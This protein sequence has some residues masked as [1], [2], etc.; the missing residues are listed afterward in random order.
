MKKPKLS[1]HDIQ[2]QILDWLK[3]HKVFHYR[4]NSGGIKKGKHFV[5][6][7]AKGAPDIVAVVKGIYWGIE[8]KKPGGLLSACQLDFR[9]ELQKSDG[10]YVVA[11]SLEHVKDALQ[12]WI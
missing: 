3:L 11:Y 5:K 4:Q 1:E 12:E 7:G 2:T 10:R 6:F 9:F 8:V